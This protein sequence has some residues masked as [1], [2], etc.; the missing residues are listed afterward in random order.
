M[1]LAVIISQGDRI[2]KQFQRCAEQRAFLSDCS[3]TTFHITCGHPVL[4]LAI[5]ALQTV[6]K[7]I[8]F[9]NTIVFV[10]RPF[11][12]FSASVVKTKNIRFVR[13]STIN[14]FRLCCI[15]KAKIDQALNTWVVFFFVCLQLRNRRFIL[16]LLTDGARKEL[17]LNNISRKWACKTLL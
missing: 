13:F 4:Y 2:K 14:D 9:R 1:L 11:K 10:K 3:G 6:Q 12:E 7:T 16:F 5:S 8:I 17:N 15:S